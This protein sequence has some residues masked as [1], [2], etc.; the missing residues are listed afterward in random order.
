M[1]GIDFLREVQAGR[2]PSAP[3]GRTV[4]FA[5]DE[6]EP[7]RAVFSLT[8]GEEHYKPPAAR[9]LDDPPPRLRLVLFFRTAPQF[10]LLRRP[11]ARAE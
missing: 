5:L 11:E 2:L 3:I 7:R 8:P 9:G 10:T 4:D 1:A 6:V